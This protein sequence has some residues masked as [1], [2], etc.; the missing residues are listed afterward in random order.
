MDEADYPVIVRRLPQSEGG[1]FIA[2]APDLPGCVADGETDVQALMDIRE[3]IAAWV[4]HAR[5]MG[6]PVP[7]PTQERRYA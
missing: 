2:I 6:R 4:E 7:A 3:A 1:G 5:E